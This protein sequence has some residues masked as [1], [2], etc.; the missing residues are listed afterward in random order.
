MSKLV[1][2]EHRDINI[3]GLSKLLKTKAHLS[4][5]SKDYFS[6]TLEVSIENDDG[7]FQIN[8]GIYWDELRQSRHPELILISIVTKMEKDIEG[9]MDE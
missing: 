8:H 5:I 7:L 9:Y 1:D 2:I 4:I 6:F 3:A